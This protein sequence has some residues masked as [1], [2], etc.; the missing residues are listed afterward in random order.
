MKSNLKFL[1][2]F[3]SLIICV[4]LFNDRNKHYYNTVGESN[5]NFFGEKI[6]VKK[7]KIE[8]LDIG[9]FI[10]FVKNGVKIVHPITNIIKVDDQIVAFETKGLQNKIKDSIVL[11]DE[12]IGKAYR[13]LEDGSIEADTKSPK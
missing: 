4:I 2:I 5:G 1:L 10:V 11:P 8:D 7:N 13:V 12:I 3:L 9:D 6:F